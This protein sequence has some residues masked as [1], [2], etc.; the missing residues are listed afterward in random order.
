MGVAKKKKEKGKIGHP[1]YLFPGHIIYLIILF[2][3]ACKAGTQTMMSVFLSGS[4]RSGAWHG[5]G[6]QEILTE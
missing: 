6:P 5:V 2:A 3:S 4:L 1:F